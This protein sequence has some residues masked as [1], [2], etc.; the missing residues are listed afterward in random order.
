MN[1]YEEA[2]DLARA[3]KDSGEFKEFD[4]ARKGIE[5]DPQLVEMVK[6]MESLQMQIQLKQAQ[7]GELDQ[8]MLNQLQSLTAMMMTK[9]QA[10]GYIQSLTRFSVMMKDVYDILAEAV[11]NKMPG[12]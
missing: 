5:S 9:P 6:R 8:D 7:G 10:A 2:H 12:M 1:V 11:G 3:I 4:Q